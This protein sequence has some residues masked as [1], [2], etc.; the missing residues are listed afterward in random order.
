MRDTNHIYY[1]I[2]KIYAIQKVLVYT[3]CASLRMSNKEA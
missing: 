2:I 3:S 1:Y